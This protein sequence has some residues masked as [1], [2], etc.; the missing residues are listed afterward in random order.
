VTLPAPTPTLAIPA[1]EKTNP[2]EKVPVELTVV[3]PDADIETDA[4]AADGT[5]IVKLLRLIPTLAIP[6]PDTTSTLLKVPL[7]LFVV[8]PEADTEME[9]VCTLAEIVTVLAAWPMPMFAPAEID[10]APVE[11]FKLDTTLE[12]EMETVI[13]PAAVA[14]C[15]L[16]FAPATR[17]KEIADPVMLVPE[18]LMVCVPKGTAVCE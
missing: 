18:A 4:A 3:F 17:A 10:I 8:L 15:K 2:V 11:P 16:M 12:P 7:E 9:E 6:A 14:V 5:E 13:A 1:P